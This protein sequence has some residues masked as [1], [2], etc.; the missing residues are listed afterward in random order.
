[1]PQKIA[2]IGGSGFIGTALTQYLHD[3]QPDAVITLLDI[4]PSSTFPDLYEQLDVCDPP[5]VAKA[6]EGMDVVFI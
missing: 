1:M 4:A 6:L 3:H 2:I 5:A